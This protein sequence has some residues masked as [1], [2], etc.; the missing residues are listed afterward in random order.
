[1]RLINSLVDNEYQNNGIDHVRRAV[2]ALVINS[3]NNKIAFIKIKKDDIFG[4]RDYYEIPGGG[5]KKNETLQK[6][7]KREI[8]EE[9]GLLIN[10][11]VP[12]GK[13]KDFY[14][15]IKQENI[16]YYYLCTID[17]KTKRNLT[18][19]EKTLFEKICWMDI[20]KAIRKYQK[21]TKEPLAR[22]IKNRELPI[23]LLVKSKYFDN[24]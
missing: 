15:L 18:N 17:R 2:R 22:L 4:Y 19:L 5:V 6:A 21:M 13:V 23:L 11:I 8:K 14:N 20:D 12:I 9:L 7:L 24:C 10:N 1:M 16:S 3:K